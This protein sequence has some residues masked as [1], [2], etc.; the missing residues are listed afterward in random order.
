MPTLYAI[1]FATVD[2]HSKDNFL[3][4]TDGINV[5]IKN[6]AT[7][8]I[9]SQ[10]IL[11][12]GPLIPTSLPLET[13]EGLNTTTKIVGSTKL[14]ITDDANKHHTY[15]IPRC[16]FDPKTPVNILGVPDLGILF[17]DNA[18]ATDPLA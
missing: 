11:F 14:I 7:A 15:I 3:W 17:G 1:A 10:R 8:I 4:D 5:V 9:S 13:A 18:D 2:D 16:V 6:S 12:T